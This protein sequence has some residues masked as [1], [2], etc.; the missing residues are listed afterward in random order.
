MK[1]LSIETSC[2]ETAIS[3]VDANGELGN[4]SFKVLANSL[5]SQALLHK[6]YG[7][8]YPTLAKREHAKNLSPLLQKTLREA[9]MF[10]EVNSPLTRDQIGELKELFTR[11]PEMFVLLIAFLGKTKKPEI[12]AITVTNG[13]GL[14]PALWI[15]VNFAKALAIVWDIPLI[16]ANHMEG[17]MLSSLI[18]NDAITPIKF[19]ALALLISGGHTQL[20]LMKDWSQYEII[21]ETRDDA[22][23]EAFDKV[24]R[25]LDLSYPG[26]PEISKLAQ[27]AREENLE[28]PFSLPRPMIDTDNF[29]FSFSGL[30]TAVLYQVKDIKKEKGKEELSETEKKQMA[31]EFEDAASEVLLEKT[32]RAI[33]KYNI[34]TFILGGGVSANKHI[35]YTLKTHLPQDVE[36]FIPPIELTGDNAIMIAAAGY[37][38]MVSGKPLPKPK[39]IVADG[40]LALS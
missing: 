3:I 4:I 28:Q 34:K 24:A 29:D 35:R 12:D 2:D 40:N 36:M 11:E 26:G 14:E 1:I 27:A 17:H 22:V 20:V 38:T 31:R 8:V 19:P 39:D 7:G 15:G 5:L 18:K 32:K 37:S 33:A 6:E 23:G 13:P 10:T 30:K 9:Q 16:P 21:G 25:M